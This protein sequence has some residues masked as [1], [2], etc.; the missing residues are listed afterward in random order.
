MDT[1]GDLM[2]SAW[3]EDQSVGALPAW[4]DNEPARMRS[5]V[6]TAVGMVNGALQLTTLQALDRVRGYAYSHG[7]TIDALAERLTTG[8]M[9][10]AALAG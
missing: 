9:D 7:S 5:Q 3:R 1:V 10:T 8:Q 6:W 2:T 4:L